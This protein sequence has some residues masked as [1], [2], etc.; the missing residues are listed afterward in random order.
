[1]RVLPF[2]P[3]L[4]VAALAFCVCAW[5]PATAGAGPSTS[6]GSALRIATFNVQNYLCMNR[7]LDGRFL[8]SYPKPESEKAAVRSVIHAVAPDIL[9]LQEVGPRPFLDELQQDLAREGLDYPH[10]ALLSGAD[11]LRHVAVL[12]RVAW[13]GVV[14]HNDLPFAYLDREEQVKRGLL[15]IQ[16]TGPSGSWRLFVVHLKSGLTEEAADRGAQK[17]R[18]AEA[19][20]VRDRIIQ[21]T[22][23]EAHPRFLLV[24]DVNDAPN[25]RTLVGLTRRGDRVIAHVVPV[26]DSRDERWTHRHAASDR[27]ERLDYVL[28][29]PALAPAILGGRGTI[30]DGPGALGGSDHRLLWIDVDPAGVGLP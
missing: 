4:A 19:R 12:S 20:V 28:A 3:R 10:A 26:T 30:Y 15:E 16:F 21:Q 17:R 6:T 1:M 23:G 9:C 8:P 18:A 2:S 29:S 11:P 27:Y 7:R 22:A 25:S 24:G 13:S 14:E 5:A